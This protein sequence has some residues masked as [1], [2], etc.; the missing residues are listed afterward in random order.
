MKRRTF[1]KGIFPTIFA[2]KLIIP[3]WNVFKIK[4]NVSY[5]EFNGIMM[6]I[7][8]QIY[9]P[10]SIHDFVSIQPMTHPTGKIIPL[11][12][13]SITKFHGDDKHTLIGHRGGY[14]KIS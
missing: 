8:K 2:P 3:I 9:P 13:T 11:E 7:I 6:P 10:L 12:F 14:G 5:S 4:P 1:L